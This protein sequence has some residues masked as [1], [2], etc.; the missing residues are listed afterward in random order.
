MFRTL[1]LTP[2]VLLAG[3]TLSGCHS[4]PG[5]PVWKMPEFLGQPIGVAKQKIGAAQ[6]ETAPDGN[7]GALDEKQSRWQQ[8][9]ATLTALWKTGNG[10]VREWTLISRDEAHALREEERG[11]LLEAG[12]L[13]ENDPLY[14]IDWIEAGGS[15]LFYTGVRVVPA[16]KNHA[17]TLRLSGPPNVVQIS[18]ETTG[19]GGKSD[20]VTVA[21][22]EQ[23][24]TLPDDTKITL[25]AAL[26]KALSPGK[27][28]FKLEIVADG[29]VVG[30][31]S[32]GGESARCEAGL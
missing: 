31:A 30:T 16:P 26:V 6:S 25:S 7:P 10:R 4:Q 8:D 13:V 29:K 3:W 23:A 22:W 18:Y 24:F 20:F 19:A 28:D 9:D 1:S 17:V 27:T 21:P 12:N 15:P 2:L 32:S 11:R 14:S 5:G